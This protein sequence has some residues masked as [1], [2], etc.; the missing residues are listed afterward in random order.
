MVGRGLL[1]GEVGH[2]IDRLGAALAGLLGDDPPLDLEDLLSSGS[3]AETDE[4]HAGRQ[5]P[6]L[7]PAMPAV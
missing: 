1:G 7:D 4:G 6:P 5:T 2:A 3:G